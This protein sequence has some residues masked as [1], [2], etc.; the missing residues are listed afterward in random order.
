MNSQTKVGRRRVL[1]SSLLA[2]GGAVLAAPAIA[3][4]LREL[5]LATA[6]P[7]DLPGV[8]TGAQR[9]AD[10][11]TRATNGR[12]TVKLYAAGEL[13][14]AFETFNAVSAGDID[15]YHGT[16]YYWEDKSKAFNFFSAVPLGL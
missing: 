2:A 4:N 5:V 9:F 10:R 3:Q 14:P 8:G 13:M 16:E 12:L 15:M 1:K 7:R 11:V 6:W